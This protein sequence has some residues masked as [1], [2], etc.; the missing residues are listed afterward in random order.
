MRKRP[1]DGWLALA[2][3]LLTIF[4]SYQEELTI[5]HV[6]TI[7]RILGLTISAGHFA[8]LLMLAIVSV[9]LYALVRGQRKREL[10]SA[11]DRAGAGRCNR[12]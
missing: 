12:S 4:W 11:G 3:I 7:V 6:P 2:P 1:A 9:L 5:V 10:L 8:I